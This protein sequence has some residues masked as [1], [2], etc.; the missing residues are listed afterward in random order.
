MAGSFPIPSPMLRERHS[1]SPGVGYDTAPDSNKPLGFA[2]REPFKRDSASLFR[3]RSRQ[4]NRRLY[5]I[6]AAQVAVALLA[7]A[8]LVLRCSIQIGS[9]NGHSAV[10]RSLS[11]SE[12]ED[13]DFQD[14]CEDM[15]VPTTSS[16]TLFST[17]SAER[18]LLMRAER[19]TGNLAEFMKQMSRVGVSIY[20][21]LRRSLLATTLGLVVVELGALASL[22]GPEFSA[23]TVAAGRIFTAAQELR[24]TFGRKVLSHNA[25]RHLRRMR[26]LLKKLQEVEK[27]SPDMPQEELFSRLESLLE[28]Q[29]TALAHVWLGLKNLASCSFSDLGAD[30]E[31]IPNILDAIKRTVMAR[32]AQVL[33]Q[34]LYR[35][36]LMEFHGQRWHFGVTTFKNIERFIEEGPRPHKENMK[37]LQS[38]ALGKLH[39]REAAMWKVQEALQ[40]SGIVTGDQSA[41]QDS[42]GEAAASSDVSASSRAS[43][44]AGSSSSRSSPVAEPSGTERGETDSRE[45]AVSRLQEAFELS[46]LVTGKQPDLGDSGE[47]FEDSSSQEDSPAEFYTPTGS[48][49]PGHT[50]DAFGTSGAERFAGLLRGPSSSEAS[51]GPELFGP[52][53]T[54]SSEVH[55]SSRRTSAGW[56]AVGS[57]SVPPPHE[58][59]GASASSETPSAF[60]L[61]ETQEDDDWW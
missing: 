32:K 23:V 30:H 18:S 54:F 53:T 24:A 39:A 20:P 17:G 59:G 28:L 25:L 58:T 31:E 57:L 16:A 48:P 61:P 34:P 10:H 47:Q 38:T 44:T 3:Q 8:Y 12:S 41:A 42:D 6:L 50:E 26:Q 4:R 36:W 11:S 1:E 52:F 40:V 22:L 37:D 56:R 15:D 27:A 55:S 13:E 60:G 45:S 33:R 9:R 5:F 21:E 51:A 29:E 46:S 14:A 19:Y 2:A 43:T 49:M 7:V 35:G